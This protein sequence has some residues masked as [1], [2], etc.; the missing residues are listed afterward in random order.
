MVMEDYPDGYL[1]KA[2][3]D[4]KIEGFGAWLGDR[5]I[6]PVVQDFVPRPRN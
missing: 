5:T 4:L 1:A 3:G 6:N 2:L